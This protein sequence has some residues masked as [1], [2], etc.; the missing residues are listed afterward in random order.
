M[1]EKTFRM[2]CSSLELLSVN[3]NLNLICVQ[4]MFLWFFFLVPIPQTMI[5]YFCCVAF[6]NLTG[7]QGHSFNNNQLAFSCGECQCDL[8]GLV[9]V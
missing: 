8:N 3:A 4:I 7:E 5:L 6:L 2:M 9:G 1:S